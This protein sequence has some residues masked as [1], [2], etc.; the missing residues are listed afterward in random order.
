MKGLAILLVVMGHLYVFSMH[1]SESDVG[2][3]ISSFHMPL[4]MFLSG[5][6]VV[7]SITPP[8]WTVGQLCRKTR[9]LLLP[10]L[11]FGGLFSLTFGT[12]AGFSIVADQI[13]RFLMAPAKNGYWY[14]MSLAVFYV[15]AQMFRLNKWNSKVMD[16]LL[17]LGIWVAFFVGWKYTA[18]T[19]DPFCLL[20]CGN[21]W[22]FF[23]GGVMSRK[24]GLVEKMMKYN[25]I[26]TVGIV[27]YIALFL[28]E[29]PIHALQSLNK[30]IFTPFCAVIVVVWLFVERED[31]T[32][33]IEEQL[34]FI[35]K[36]TLDVYMIHYFIVSNINLLVVDRWL[37]ANG[38]TPLSFVLSLT[39]SVPITY[40]SIGLGKILHKSNLIEKFVY[41]KS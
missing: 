26:L 2:K 40:A 32:S 23:I 17:A 29:M 5:Y 20:N 25:W 3:W 39:I 11:V 15:T 38:N 8:Y 22:L 19:Y 33:W 37:E 13:I 4:F 24:Y 31:K 30:H 18:Q 10:M 28:I 35:G 16:V 41:G 27:G 6:V 1:G 12:V 21:F 9:G 14:L 34:S 36:N 7:K